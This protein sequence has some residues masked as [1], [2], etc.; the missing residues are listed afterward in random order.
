MMTKWLLIILTDENQFRS[1]TVRWP[2]DPICGSL[3]REANFWGWVTKHPTDV[4]REKG[5]AR[6][7]SGATPKFH[8]IITLV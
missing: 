1:L 2:W 7:T 4:V 6:R 3:K 5:R 8:E